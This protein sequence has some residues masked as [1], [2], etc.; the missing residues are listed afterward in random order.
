MKYLLD[1]STCISLLRYG[2]SSPV[3]AKLTATAPGEAV[4]CEIVRIELL[5]GALRSQ[6]VAASMAQVDKLFAT[7]P[8]LA[9]DRAA[10]DHCAAI[11]FELASVGTPIGPYDGM[12]ARIARSRGLIVVTTNVGEFSR[13]TGLLCENWSKP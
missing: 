9:L 5:Y 10:A 2:M 11:R 3:D 13:V 8:S 6:T 7:L 1:T 12:I 4:L